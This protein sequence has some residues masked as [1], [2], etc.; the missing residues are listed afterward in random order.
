M[1]RI[2]STRSN[3][4]TPGVEHFGPTPLKSSASCGSCESE[5]KNKKGPALVC[6][7]PAVRALALHTLGRFCIAIAPN[8]LNGIS[9]ARILGVTPGDSVQWKF[10]LIGDLTCR[11]PLPLS[12][13]SQHSLNNPLVL[14]LRASASP[15]GN[16][17]AK[18]PCPVTIFIIAGPIVFVKRFWQMWG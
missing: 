10:P 6:G 18:I 1:N 8:R 16:L 15:Q 7:S 3:C 13:F 9:P 11:T 5:Y 14:P 4:A 2:C 12:Y 17:V